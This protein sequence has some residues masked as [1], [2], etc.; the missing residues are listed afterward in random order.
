MHTKNSI[1]VDEDHDEIPCYT[2][3]E[4]DCKTKQEPEILEIEYFFASELSVPD[5][6]TMSA[7]TREEVLIE[8]QTDE[9]FT[10]L[11]VLISNKSVSQ[12]EE[13][14]DGI[15]VRNIGYKQ[16]IVPKSLR[17]R[18]MMLAHRP[19][20]SA[21]PGSRKMYAT[22]PR[23]HYW[24]MMALDCHFFS[25]NCQE[26]ARER[27]NLRR[28][29]KELVLFPANA[30]LESVAL[31]IL[32]AFLKTPRGPTHILVIINRYS[33]LT[34]TSTLGKTNVHAVAMYFTHNRGFT[35]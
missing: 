1:E 11:R 15:L 35:H 6:T 33:K 2:V 29:T 25:C 22:L 8:Q 17:Q 27:V 30:S 12:Y 19:V 18:I 34:R 20:C 32:G 4:L 14:N 31:D 7:V 10:E 21:H 9:L 26:C 23:T 3:S 28:N 24:P 13:D 5:R 16:V